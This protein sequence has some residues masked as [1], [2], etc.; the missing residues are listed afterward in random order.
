MIA[1]HEGDLAVHRKYHVENAR[2][3]TSATAA[4]ARPK[5]QRFEFSTAGLPSNER[6]AAW[7]ESYSSVL[8]LRPRE[9]GTKP[10]AGGSHEVWDLGSFVFSRVRTES[11]SFAGL[12][13][14]GRR[15]PLDHWLLT[16][17]LRGDTVTMA[18]GGSLIGEAGSVQVHPLGRPFEGHISGSELLML[19][20][21]RDL[22]RDQKQVLD[23]ISFTRLH[24]GMGRIFAD[25]MTSL[26]FRLPLMAKSDLPDLTAAT[27]AML[28]ACAE[29][30]A[31]RLE[32]AD[33][34]V[35]R[36]LLERARQYIQAHLHDPELHS[37]MLPRSLG[38]SRSRLYR[39]FEV[40]GGVM[41]YI[42]RRRLAAAHA[43]LADP[44]DE[45]RIVEIAQSYCFGDGAEF[46]RAFRREYGYS[47]SDVRAGRHRGLSGSD[48]EA[49]L[50]AAYAP[51]QRLNLLLRRLQG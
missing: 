50:D 40:S 30:S 21:P 25:Y 51:S 29:P 44:H 43:A 32:E 17:L 20:I 45:R 14:H 5:L 33:N 10:F 49:Y 35:S 9:N 23:A 3:P 6:F 41:H 39:L 12:A 36:L 37:R 38:T 1:F 26:A 8:D 34:T 22:C 16:L 28:L 4:P 13:G 48:G 7:R 27:R 31:E 2:P 19:F 47:P 24:G 11:L 42:Q 15:D 46:S 18:N